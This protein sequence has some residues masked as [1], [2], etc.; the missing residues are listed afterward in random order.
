MQ[1][2]PPVAAQV[3]LLRAGHY[4]D[5]Q[6][7]VADDRAHGMHPRPAVG[8]H[9]GQESQAYADLKKL[10][11]ARGGEGGL[12]AGELGPSDHAADVTGLSLTTCVSDS[13]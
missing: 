1:R 6:A 8:P 10:G 5:M 3:L 4:Q 7:R 9:S 11:P 2:V 13:P 12:A